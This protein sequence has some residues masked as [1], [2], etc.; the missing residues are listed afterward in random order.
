MEKMQY[1]VTLKSSILKSVNMFLIPTYSFYSK[2]VI[3]QLLV[4]HRKQSALKGNW[5]FIAC[6]SGTK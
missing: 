3:N 4:F 1:I 5:L 6:L 2:Q